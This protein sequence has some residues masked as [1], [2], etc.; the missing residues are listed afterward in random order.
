M[1][2][3]M[4]EG[5]RQQMLPAKALAKAMRELAQAMLKVNGVK[6]PKRGRGGSQFHR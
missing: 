3:S 5:Q 6:Q 1:G 2:E 4:A